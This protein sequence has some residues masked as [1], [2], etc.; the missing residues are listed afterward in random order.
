MGAKGGY[1]TWSQ[2]ALDEVREFSLFDAQLLK[3]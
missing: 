2:K 1:G 3:H